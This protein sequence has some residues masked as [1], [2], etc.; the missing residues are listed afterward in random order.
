MDKHPRNVHE[1]LGNSGR[2]IIKE[3]H[4]RIKLLKYNLT[5]RMKEILCRYNFFIYCTIEQKDFYHKHIL[6][7]KYFKPKKN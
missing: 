5:E 6:N 3:E 4:I 7:S 2:N 1:R